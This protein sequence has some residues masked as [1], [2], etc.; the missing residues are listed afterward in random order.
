MLKS[1]LA[2][3]KNIS[4]A[5]RIAALTLTFS[6]RMNWDAGLGKKTAILPIRK[7]DTRGNG[8]IIDI[9]AHG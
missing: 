2:G 5:W 1:R 9:F 8:G 3:S 4:S 6:L 7:K